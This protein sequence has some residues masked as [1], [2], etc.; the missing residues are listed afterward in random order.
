MMTSQTWRQ[1]ILCSFQLIFS[2]SLSGLN[3]E[4]LKVTYDVRTMTGNDFL[5]TSKWIWPTRII[6]WVMFTCRNKS[7]PGCIFI[8]CLVRR[9]FTFSS[10]FLQVCHPLLARSK[11]EINVQPLASALPTRVYHFGLERKP[12]FAW[13]VDCLQM[14]CVFHIWEG[15]CCVSGIWGWCLLWVQEEWKFSH[16]SRNLSVSLF[17]CHHHPNGLTPN[18]QPTQTQRTAPCF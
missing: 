16:S 6:H 17:Q 8:L 3:K 1:R 2:W 9:E 13:S 10:H 18:A 4:V 15:G 11:W 12:R 7:F 14:S 5:S